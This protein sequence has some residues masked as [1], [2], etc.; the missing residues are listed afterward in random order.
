MSVSEQHVIS[1]RGLRKAYGEQEAVRGIDL[2]IERGEIFGFLGPNGAGK[3]TTVEILEG[4]RPRTAGDVWVLGVD[5]AKPTRAWR[6]RIGLVLQE[7][8]LDAT[9]T[10]HETVRGR[11]AGSRGAWGSR[12][13]VS[14]E[15][16]RATPLAKTL[17]PAE[18]RGGGSNDHIAPKRQRALALWSDVVAM[19]TATTLRQNAG[20]L[21]RFGAKGVSI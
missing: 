21:C 15:G 16:R 14:W 6:E 13:G 18:A 3:S 5:P 12:R 4:Y 20:R 8:E 17:R 1:V 19:A 7:S 9:L 2:D 10:V 11:F